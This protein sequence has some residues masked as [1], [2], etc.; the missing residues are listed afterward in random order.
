MT[1]G[2]GDLRAD[3]CAPVLPRVVER[4]PRAL[5]TWVLL[6]VTVL[7]VVGAALYLT[8]PSATMPPLVP[9]IPPMPGWEHRYLQATAL[10]LLA[11]AT[12]TTAAVHYAVRRRAF[13]EDAMFAARHL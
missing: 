10:L 11:A 3:V 7:A 2:R 12:G 8:L 9:G 5:V 1:G 13:T 6:L 4:P